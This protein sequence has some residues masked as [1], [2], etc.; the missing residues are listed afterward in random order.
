MENFSKDW[1]YI[2]QLFGYIT[3]MRV[4]MFDLA[5]KN[6]STRYSVV[7]EVI[8]P[9][10]RKFP[11]ISSFV[12]PLFLSFLFSFYLSISISIVK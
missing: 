4:A 1:K 7:G 8:F 11:F 12:G 10:T 6:F 5:E 9:D 2:W 3:K